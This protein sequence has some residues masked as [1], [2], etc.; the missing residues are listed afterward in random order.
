MYSPSSAG[1]H[2]NRARIANR[3][4]HG[5]QSVPGKSLPETGSLH[6]SSNA[7]LRNDI[8]GAPVVIATLTL[9]L[10]TAVSPK[11]FVALVCGLPR[12]DRHA[13]VRPRQTTVQ[14]RN[15]TIPCKILYPPVL[16]CYH[17]LCFDHAISLPTPTFHGCP[18]ASLLPLNSVHSASLR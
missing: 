11:N 8:W 10:W 2:F 14:P 17:S 5:L 12:Q 15:S 7:V 1:P 3:I 6:I 9:G 4:Y 16:G 13:A 18:P